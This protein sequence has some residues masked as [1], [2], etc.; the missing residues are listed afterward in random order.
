VEIFGFAALHAMRLSVML[1]CWCPC[2]GRGDL[3]ESVHEE[4]VW[5]TFVRV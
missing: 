1:L 2:L 3:E 4:S 5:N